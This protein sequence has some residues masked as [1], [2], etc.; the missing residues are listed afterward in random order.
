M[1]TVFTHSSTLV[2]LNGLGDG[3]G[4]DSGV[5]H[6]RFAAATMKR[7][8]QEKQVS[9]KSEDMREKEKRRETGI[10]ED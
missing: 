3:S 8:A 4:E 9:K 7:N 5:Y 2:G 1:T 10:G 6:K